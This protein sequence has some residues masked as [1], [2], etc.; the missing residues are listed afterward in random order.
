M[1]IQC[2]TVLTRQTHI[3]TIAM[4]GDKGGKKD[5]QSSELLDDHTT[6][7][8]ATMNML[9]QYA[10]AV[11]VLHKTQPKP[12]PHDDSAQGVGVVDAWFT[13]RETIQTACVKVECIRNPWSVYAL[14]EVRG[15][16]LGPV[17]L[18]AAA[19]AL[20]GV[21]I[22]AASCEA[23]QQPMQQL[24]TPVSARNSLSRSTNQPPSSSLSEELDACLLNLIRHTSKEA[25]DA[26][27]NIASSSLSTLT[28]RR[29]IGSNSSSQNVDHIV[30]ATLI[31][32]TR[33]IELALVDMLLLLLRSISV[34]GHLTTVVPQVT[35]NMNNIIT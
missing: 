35:N 29:E 23:M 4:R 15:N 34:W 1:A 32:H 3:D 7:A 31:D 2:L 16:G 11:I 26:M 25:E 24:P 9:L 10:A 12:R 17:A 6:V 5:N 18:T 33:T 20:I 19:S 28:N 27:R 13:F 22:F 30:D 14:A 8:L 21:S